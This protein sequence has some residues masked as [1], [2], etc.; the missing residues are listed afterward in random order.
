MIE[1]YNPQKVSNLFLIKII[2]FQKTII[3]NQY[4]GIALFITK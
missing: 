2:F 3:D 4:L 1:S